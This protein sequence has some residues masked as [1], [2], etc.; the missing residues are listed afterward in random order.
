[1]TFGMLTIFF[2]QHPIAV[3]PGVL[4]ALSIGC[5]VHSARR[6]RRAAAVGASA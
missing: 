1:M 2:T 6:A 5:A 4:I 3:F